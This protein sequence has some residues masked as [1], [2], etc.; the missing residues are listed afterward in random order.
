MKYSKKGKTYSKKK[1]T[2]KRSIAFYNKK[3]SA[4]DLAKKALAGLSYVKGMINCERHKMEFSDVSAPTITNTGN[5]YHLTGVNQDDTDSGRTGNSLL[6]RGLYYSYT[7]RNSNTPLTFTT[8]RVMI[9]Q[10][11]QQIS[12]SSPSNITGILEYTSGPRVVNSPLDSA[13]VGRWKI[14]H[15]SRLELD[16]VSQPQVSRTGY[17]PLRHHIRYNGTGSA[18]IQK[19]GIYCIFMADQAAANNPFLWQMQTRLYF[20]DN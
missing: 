16:T 5:V 19:G 11:Q 14:L 1:A 7:I 8:V 4:L 13:T 6:A 10:D 17:I 20:Y 15:D 12:D 2:R 18:D 9:I 3:Y